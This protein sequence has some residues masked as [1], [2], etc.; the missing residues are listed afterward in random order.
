MAAY[1]AS[2][3]NVALSSLIHDLNCP[4]MYILDGRQE[5]RRSLLGLLGK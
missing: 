1:H 2:D 5:V 3:W 4:D